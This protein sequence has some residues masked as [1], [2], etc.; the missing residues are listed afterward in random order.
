[1]TN[2]KTQ[3][4]GIIGED[5][6]HSLSPIIHSAAFRTKK[7]NYA[8]LAF[9]VKKDNLKDTVN[10]LKCLGIRGFNVT[11]PFK[12]EI[13]PLLDEL[14]ETASACGAVNTVVS[15]NGRLKG[16]N[17]DGFGAISA[18]KEEQVD[19]SHCLILG[20]GGAASAI[21][22][23]FAKEGAEVCILN[24]TREKAVALA[25]KLQELGLKVTGG[26]LESL[27]KEM[28]KATIVIN[29]SSV[30]FN[31]NESLVPKELLNKKTALMD[32][33]YH[34][35]E[36]RLVHEAREIGCAVITGE[37]MLLHQ[38]TRAFELWTGEK[39][40]EMAMEKALY[41]NLKQNIVLIGIMGSG[42]STVGKKL[43]EEKKLKLV[44]LDAEIE[45][46]AGMSIKEIFSQKGEAAFRELEA[47]C[48][49][50]HFLDTQTVFATGGGIILD[51]ENRRIISQMGT[52]IW[53]NI[54]ANQ[55]HERTV[56]DITRPILE[57]P[58]RKEILEKVLENRKPIYQALCDFEINAG[59]K[60]IEEVM[61]EIQA[62]IVQI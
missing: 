35:L 12:Q 8:Y 59:E 38:A 27:G 4:I 29:A 55:A 47:K 39:P 30:G 54:S 44:D 23:A 50:R 26:G 41:Q 18:A 36:T 49:E 53:L 24:K 5:V 7:L 19:F 62:R 21:A 3:L 42:K 17:T 14:D 2:A 33:N 37:R 52:V 34:P 16:F 6:T 56:G 43:A 15:D 9:N 61:A 51:E 57:K 1:M 25:N 60:S 31:S 40:D 48:L 32:V 28:K 10:G 20:A 13:I 22:Y 45:E 46:N 58:N 11:A